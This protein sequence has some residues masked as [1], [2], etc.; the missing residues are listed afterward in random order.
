MSQMVKNTIK[1]CLITLVAGILLGAVYEVTKVPRKNQEEKTQQQAYKKVFSQADSFQELSHIVQEDE[2]QVYKAAQ[3]YIASK[4]EG[5]VL[6]EGEVL[7]DKVVYAY[8]K[9]ECKGCVVTVT[10]KEGFGGDI[11]FTVGVTKEGTISGVSVLSISETAGLG[12]KAKE[13]SFLKQYKQEEKIAQFTVTKKGEEGADKIDAIS[14]ATI[15]TNAV[16]KGVNG[17]MK[18]AG[19]F[20]SLENSSLQEGGETNE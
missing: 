20:M 14:G 4:G 10:S 15:T 18:A 6:T 2:E 11:Q 17:A 9:E 19:Y 13:D 3:E 16:T 5:A 8:E 12:M 7:I 1:L